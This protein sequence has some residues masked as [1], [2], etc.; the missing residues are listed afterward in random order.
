MLKV[1]RLDF[2]DLTLGLPQGEGQQGQPSS[3]SMNQSLHGHSG[4][5]CVLAWNM[6][7]RRLA[8][9]DDTGLIIVWMLQH[10][11][12]Q[13]GREGQWC[14]EMINNRKKSH[15]VDMQWTARGDR[16]CIAYEDG[17]VIVE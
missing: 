9:A 16:I 1:L 4:K 12:K 6:P 7:E 8:S 14:E 15:V 2:S 5:V 13:E 10:H 3:L 11:D 17:G